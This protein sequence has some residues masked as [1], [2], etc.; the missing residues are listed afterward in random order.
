MAETPE[1]FTYDDDGN[2]LSDGRFTY[3]WDAENR[4]ITATT[5]DN[6]P[7]DLPRVRV[8]HHYDHRSRRIATARETWSGTAW[9]S[10]GTNRYLYDGWNVVAEVRAA[11]PANTNLNVWGLD[12]SGSLQ[13]AGGIGGLLTVR[14]RLEDCTGIVRNYDYL[15]DANGNVVQET[16]RTD[17]AI[18]AHYEYDPFGNTVVAL[19]VDATDNPFRFSTK[20]FDNDTGLGYWGYR[21]YGP[22][23]GR[24]MSRDPIGERGGLSELMF[25]RNRPI[26]LH[27]AFGLC[28]DTEAPSSWSTGDSLVKSWTDCTVANVTMLIEK[29]SGCAKQGCWRLRLDEIRM[30]ITVKNCNPSTIKHEQ[31]HVNDLRRISCGDTKRYA[32]S[33]EGCY[34]LEKAQCW[35]KVV[36]VEAAEAFYWLGKAWTVAFVDLTEYPNNEFYHEQWKW[37][38]E[39][40]AKART[41]MRNAESMCSAMQ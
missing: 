13:G 19:R 36:E 20:W 37:L 12:L 17:G 33:K 16:F 1:A 30:Q 21:W 8:T 24:W 23:L 25:A 10:A 32:R 2:L 22:G 6:L 35:K 40:Y 38:D 4:L 27:D 7:A 18:N 11:S 28:S 15:F 34:S 5:R 26:S 14:K 29:D 3:S 39:Q 41:A 9:Q 31:K